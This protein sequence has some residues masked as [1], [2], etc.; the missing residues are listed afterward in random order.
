MRHRARELALQI[1]FQ[2][3]FAPQISPREFMSVFEE[4]LDKETLVFAE[5]LIDGVL[6]NQD[7][8]D[9]KIGAASRHWKIERMGAVDR[10]VLRIAVFEMKFVPSPLKSGIIIDEAVEIAKRFGTTES[11]AF[12]NGIL[13]QI[14]R[15]E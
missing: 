15:S 14:S 11:G 9:A 4:T 6:D 7:A 1:L 10:N 2:T 3:E 13:D 8:I 5:D 12:V